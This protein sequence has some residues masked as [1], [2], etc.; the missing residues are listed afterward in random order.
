MAMLLCSHW[1]RYVATFYILN[2]MYN[3]NTTIQ[4]V[5][6]FANKNYYLP[7]AE[8]LHCHIPQ[9]FTYETPDP[10]AYKHIKNKRKIKL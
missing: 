2:Y 4:I 5:L 7:K 6:K 9:N 10:L 1:I 8:G 3:V